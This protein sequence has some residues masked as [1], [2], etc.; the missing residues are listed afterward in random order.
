MSLSSAQL[1][2]TPDGLYHWVPGEM[3]VVV[4]LPR[5]PSDETLD[6]LTEQVRVQLNELLT[7]YGMVLEPY[8]SHGRWSTTPTMPPV[9]RRAFVFGLHGKQPLAAIFFHVRH[10]NPAIADPLPMALSYVQSQLEHLAQV[11]LWIVSAMPNWLMSAAP[12]YYADGGPALP[13][14]PTPLLDIPS[15]ANSLLGWHIKQV[16]PVIPLDTKG[17][18]DVLVAVLDTAPHPDRIR[19]AA[20]RPEWRRHWLLQRLAQEL[21]NED[22]TFVVEYDRYS[23]TNDVSTGKDFRHEPRYYLMPDHGLAVAGL[24]RDVAPRARIRLIRVLNDYGGGDLFG[25][26]AALSDL[27]REFVKGSIRR[28]VV[29]L[30]LNIMPDIRRL[31]YIWFDHRQWPTTQ[32]GGVT[33]VLNHIE[34]GL[35]Q[36]FEGL[37][38]HGILVTAAAG[39]DSFHAL[40]QGQLP[41]PP[42]VPARYASTLSVT[43]VNSKFVPASFANAA[44][45]PPIETGVA[46]FGGDS[47]GVLDANSMQDAV[48]GIY[49]SPT[50]PAGEQNVSGWA[51][52][53]GTSFA[54]PI[55][56]ALGA[57][58]MAQGWSATNI[59]AR[60]SGGQ[61][62]RTDKLFGSPPEAPT[63]LANIMRVQQTFGL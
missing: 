46:T 22:G 43:A 21:R 55:I 59:L 60:L 50:L 38:A 52:W 18:D 45:I 36:L 8:G 4:R 47:Y 27:E 3:V 20:T 5:L 54:T 58:L 9:R 24:V 32:L 16:D 48:R 25:L 56:S 35:R 15:A 61:E 51:D 7:R 49:I 62:R 30:S 40:Q 28:L 34:E 13:P 41:R 1:M 14:R 29:N 39:N 33:R 17:A 2:G 10:E 37:Y 12:I 31:P 11:G 57:H 42:R 19:S 53:S 23:P 44:N 6:L 26:I 63:V